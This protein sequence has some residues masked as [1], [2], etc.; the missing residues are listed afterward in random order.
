MQI[1]KWKCPGTKALTYIFMIVS[2]HMETLQI[3]SHYYIGVNVAV[4]A[5]ALLFMPKHCAILVDSIK[6][7]P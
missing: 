4:V 2:V 3:S 7:A 6:G 1:T 5:K